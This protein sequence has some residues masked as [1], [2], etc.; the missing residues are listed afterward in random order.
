MADNHSHPT[1]GLP[2]YRRDL[3]TRALA[4]RV[5]TTFVLL[6]IA[7]RVLVLLIM[8]RRM[9]DLFLH[10]G[11]THVHHLNYGIF[12]LCAVGGFLLFVR[13]TGR[14]PLQIAAIAYGVGLALTFDEFGMWLHLG[15]GYWQRA[16]YDAVITVAALLALIAFMPMP[17]HWNARQWIV[18]VVLVVALIVLGRMTLKALSAEEIKTQPE[19]EQLE[20]RGPQ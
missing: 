1:D 18:A 20:D 12:L 7:S 8:S 11:G 15:G 10:L 16:S 6:F 5:L 14:R 17:N 2:P 4:R 3:S 19:L 9:P 13:P